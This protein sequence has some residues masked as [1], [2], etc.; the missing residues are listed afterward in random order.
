MEPGLTTRAAD[1]RHA[2]TLPSFEAAFLVTTQPRL[3][4]LREGRWYHRFC[5]RDL[6]DGQRREGDS[7]HKQG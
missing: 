5:A 2:R 1:L 4:P 3:Q 6:C 7:R